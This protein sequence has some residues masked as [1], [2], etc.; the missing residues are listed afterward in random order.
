M[1]LTRKKCNTKPINKS[2]NINHIILATKVW[3]KYTDATNK[4]I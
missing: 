2:P 1:H 3:I 4:Y